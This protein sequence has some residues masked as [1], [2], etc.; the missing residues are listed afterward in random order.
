MRKQADRVVDLAGMPGQAD[1]Q[2]WC[3]AVGMQD[4]GQV[5]GRD[6]ALVGEVGDLLVV[7]LFQDA[8]AQRRVGCA[9]QEDGKRGRES[10]LAPLLA[11]VVDAVEGTGGRAQCLDH[12]R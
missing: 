6:H 9:L 5:S 3:R 1:D 10:L 2:V 8:P 4:H 11:T 7:G 12:Y